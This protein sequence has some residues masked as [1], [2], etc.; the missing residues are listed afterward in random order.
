LQKDVEY[1]VHSA[2]VAAASEAIASLKSDLAAAESRAN[3]ERLKS[4]WAFE[5][6]C[7]SC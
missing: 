6:F 2:I 3:G 1:L 5:S 4:F 7:L